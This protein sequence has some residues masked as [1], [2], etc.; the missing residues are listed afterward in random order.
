M[1]NQLRTFVGA[2]PCSCRDSKIPVANVLIRIYTIIDVINHELTMVVYDCLASAIF[3]HYS[4]L[5]T[6]NPHI[7]GYSWVP[8]WSTRFWIV[9]I[10]VEYWWINSCKNN[11]LWSTLVGQVIH[12]RTL[13]YSPA[14][15]IHKVGHR[16]FVYPLWWLVI[17]ADYHEPSNNHHEPPYWW[18][19]PYWWPS[20][21]TINNHR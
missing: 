16:L 11:P 17:V 7:V 20:L 12:H 4:P 14:I 5:W 3:C 1:K 8:L 10:D 18:P 21:T 9:Q 13:S 15:K 2:P 6:S 19:N